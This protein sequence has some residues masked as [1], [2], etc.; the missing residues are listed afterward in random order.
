LK[1]KSHP[2]S[3]AARVWL[4]LIKAVQAIGRQ[5]DA[6]LLR[7]NLNGTEF[8]ILELLLH[9]GPLPVNI[10]GPKVNLTAGAISVAVNRLLERE[11]VS[12]EENP[13]DRRIRT[14]ALTKAGEKLIGPVYRSHEALLERVMEPLN[15]EQRATLEKLLETIGRHAVTLSS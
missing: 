12:R 14:V 5:I 8:R 6:D 10:I 11:F 13:L 9:K 4:V 1:T 3:Q 2:G 15:R 7:F